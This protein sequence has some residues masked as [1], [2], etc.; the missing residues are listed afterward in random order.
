MKKGIVIAIISLLIGTSILPTIGGHNKSNL[1][2]NPDQ[3]DQEQPNWWLGGTVIFDCLFAAQAFKPNLNVLSKVELWLY[4]YNYPP[5]DLIISIRKVLTGPDLRLVTIPKE[6]IDWGPWDNYITVDF[7]DLSVIPEINYFIVA[8]T[9][10]GDFNNLFCWDGCG[11]TNNYPRGNCWLSENC[12]ST[13]SEHKLTDLCFRTYGYNY[14]PIE[15]SITY[16]DDGD[17]V[18]GTISINGTVSDA[19]GIGKVKWVMIQ[20]DENDW[21]EIDYSPTGIWT[22]IWDSTIV[23]DGSHIVSAV[24]SDGITQSAVVSKEFFVKNSEA[25]DDLDQQQTICDTYDI[26]AETGSQRAQSFQP[27]KNKL[28]RVRLLMYKYGDPFGDIILIL[29]NSINGTDLATSSK[30]ANILPLEP[31]MWIE[32]NF[33]NIS[34]QPGQTYYLIVLGNDYWDRSAHLYWGISS[35]DVYLNGSSWRYDYPTDKWIQKPD[36][37]YCFKTYGFNNTPPNTPTITG[38]TNGIAG[39]EYEYCL[40]YVVDLDG[41]SVYV[42]WDWGDGTNTG[43][44]GPYDS[45]EPMCANH[46][47]SEEGTYTVKAKLKDP[48]GGESDWASLEVSM[49]K[50]KAINIP[51]F[52]QRFFQR[53]PFFERILNQII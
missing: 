4:K 5:N 32:F 21:I 7:P 34:V 14:L 35:S 53:F 10:G 6:D 24:A 38:K 20:I 9:S 27:M 45:G 18:N 26:I 16:P 36:N 41:D 42:W 43:W 28:T 25:S 48:F 49:P 1:L 29:R 37:D 13:W 17:T 39:E 19:D 33:T 40:N 30:P 46:S 23:E 15:V 12:G 51:L 31:A 52:L 22:Y 44:L 47:W 11:S 3:L 2:N 8:R 50:N